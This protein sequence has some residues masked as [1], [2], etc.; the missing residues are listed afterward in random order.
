[1]ALIGVAELYGCWSETPC[2]SP[3]ILEIRVLNLSQDSDCVWG[4]G[5]KVVSEWTQ[6]LAASLVLSLVQTLPPGFLLASMLVG[7]RY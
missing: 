4:E 2:G 1:M 3:E 6:I 7:P 5:R